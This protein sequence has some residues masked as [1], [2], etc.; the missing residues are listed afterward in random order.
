MQ[1]KENAITAILEKMFETSI[2][3]IILSI[4]I[5]RQWNF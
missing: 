2:N 4:L 5:L 1:T 3:Q